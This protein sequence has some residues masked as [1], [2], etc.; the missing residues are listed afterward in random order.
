MEDDEEYDEEVDDEEPNQRAHGREQRPSSVHQNLTTNASPSACLGSETAMEPI[1]ITL[2][3]ADRVKRQLSMHLQLLASTFV[4]TINL[5]DLEETLCRPITTFVD[6]IH[7]TLHRS[8]LLLASLSSIRNLLPLVNETRKFVHEFA[9]LSILPCFS[10]SS[11]D[12]AQL[13]NTPSIPLPFFLMDYILRSALW[14]YPDLLPPGLAS[15]KALVPPR[16]RG[17]F[18]ADEDGLIVLG[19]ANFAEASPKRFAALVE[20]CNSDTPKTAAGDKS[21]RMHSSFFR[22]VATNLL[23]TRTPRQLYCRKCYVDFFGRLLTQRKSTGFGPGNSTFSSRSPLGLL[24]QDFQ[25]PD[26]ASVEAKLDLLRSCVPAFARQ[27]SSYRRTYAL[28]SIFSR[29]DVWHRLPAEYRACTSS[30]ARQ[31]TM[32]CLLTSAPVPTR[33]CLNVRFHASSA[34]TH[35]FDEAMLS[36]WPSLEDLEGTAHADPPPFPVSAVTSSLTSSFAVGNPVI[37]GNLVVITSLPCA[38]VEPV[39]QVVLPPPSITVSSIL[40]PS[41]AVVSHQPA[42]KVATTP[43]LSR[44]PFPNH[45]SFTVVPSR[46]AFALN[47]SPSGC[48][49]VQTS[50]NVS[51]VC[52]STQTS[53]AT[54]PSL[55]SPLKSTSP[56]P[57]SIIPPLARPFLPLMPSQSQLDIT[58]ASKATPGTAS[59]RPIAPAPPSKPVEKSGFGVSS[60]RSF[61]NKPSTLLPHTT[62]MTINSAK[63]IRWKRRKSRLSLSGDN[64]GTL[65][66]VTIPSLPTSETHPSRVPGITAGIVGGFRR[67]SPRPPNIPRPHITGT[68]CTLPNVRPAAARASSRSIAQSPDVVKFIQSFNQS[69]D[70]VRSTLAGAATTAIEPTSRR[71]A[72]T[73][74]IASTL[75]TSNSRPVVAKFLR[76]CGCKKNGGG[77]DDLLLMTRSR[78]SGPSMQLTWGREADEADVLYART[79][80]DRCRVYLSPAEHSLL[81]TSFSDLSNCITDQCREQAFHSPPPL[82]KHLSTVLN[83]LAG[84]RPLW[85]DFVCLLTPEQARALRLFPVYAHTSRVRSLQMALNCL[86]PSGKRFWCRLRKLANSRE[87]EEMRV[88]VLTVAKDESIPQ[89]PH[90]MTSNWR[91]FRRRT[92]RPKPK[93]IKEVLKSAWSLLESSLRSRYVFLAQASACLEP[94]HR[95][96]SNFPQAFEVV[97]SLARRPDPSATPVF[98]SSVALSSTLPRLVDEMLPSITTSA[99]SNLSSETF[100]W[101]ISTELASCTAAGPASALLQQPGLSVGGAYRLSKTTTARQCPCPCH[102][103]QPAQKL[104]PVTAAVA[105][106]HTLSTSNPSGKPAKV[107]SLGLRHCIKCSLRVHQ[108]VV[109]VDEC[110]FHLNHVQITWPSDFAFQQPV[111]S[112]H[113]F[114]QSNHATG[115]AVST[116]VALESLAAYCLDPLSA[117]SLPDMARRQVAVQ[118]GTTVAG[119]AGTKGGKTSVW[120][121]DE[122]EEEELDAESAASSPVASPSTTSGSSVSSA[123]LPL[124]SRPV[125]SPPSATWSSEVDDEAACFNTEAFSRNSGTRPIG[126]TS[127]LTVATTGA[128]WSLAEDRRLL[129]YCRGAG[130]YSRVNLVL[131]ASVW[132]ERTL[133]EIV[134]RFKY[135]MRIALGEEDQQTHMFDSATE[136]SQSSP[137]TALDRTLCL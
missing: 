81:V 26:F 105:T 98:N 97:D 8:S 54:P 121:T 90:T 110:N 16:Q 1:S 37:S 17:L 62:T 126:Y 114:V 73:S 43:Y 44:P 134:N 25:S 77:S 82:L 72:T 27:T 136:S 88:P 101:E 106:S 39:F 7:A 133:P 79:F 6:Q 14:P 70:R 116:R 52:R 65:A 132:P 32:S 85:E 130:S 59:L 113:R 137:T 22:F 93:S 118:F 122:N 67:I 47:E 49:L 9:G 89:H 10:S 40:P 108:G 66:S 28:G 131:L 107:D 30:L 60:V 56:K 36:W 87:P 94:N 129:E 18:T 128:P 29:P 69:L 50:T 4:A 76:R 74:L 135:L 71:N 127:E 61:S 80:L 119:A 31:M 42:K 78:R 86:I 102:D 53:V 84:C 48:S 58:L 124:A 111:R 117:P 83:C 33:D 115:S 63:C 12:R 35:F 24:L 55:T 13:L 11:E 5:S 38:P 34:I 3:M 64:K 45:P 100:R 15:P 103:H 92:R 57:P 123:A 112:R 99:E 104:L 68:L 21:P 109:F 125:P 96:Y 51:V 19:I 91:A 75:S 20:H 41:T 2:D 120:H 95:P 46:S 23:P